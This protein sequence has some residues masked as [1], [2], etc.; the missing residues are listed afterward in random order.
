MFKQWLLRTFFGNRVLLESILME[1]RNI[2]YHFDRMESFYMT[3][4]NIKEEKKTD[5]EDK[6]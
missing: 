3:V 4:N 1:L 6:N 5:K 2:H